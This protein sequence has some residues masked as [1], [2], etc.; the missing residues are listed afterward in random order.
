MFLCVYK[1][2][3][4]ACVYETV[5]SLKGYIYISPNQGT[6]PMVVLLQQHTVRKGGKRGRNRK[7]LISIAV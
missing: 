4:Y 6:G 3:A 1:T 2:H 5:Q 7:C